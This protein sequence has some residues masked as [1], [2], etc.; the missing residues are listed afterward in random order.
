MERRE[1]LKTV[2]ATAAV[3]VSGRAAWSGGPATAGPAGTTRPARAPLDAAAANRAL[4]EHRIAG[5][6]LRQMRDRFPRLVGPGAR[7]RPTGHGGGFRVRIVTT[8]QGVSGWA[9]SGGAGGEDRLRGRRVSDCFS[10]EHGIASDVPGFLDRVLHDLAGRIL[11]RPVYQLLGGAGPTAVPIYSS[12][13]H[14][15]DLVPAGK[16]GGVPRLLDCCKQDHRAGYRAFKLKIGR[17]FRWMKRNEGLRRDIAITRSVREHFPDCRLLVDAND[18]Y[19]VAEAIAYVKAVADCDLYWI[20]EPFEENRDGLKRLRAAMA[21]V[22]CKAM[23]AD[24]ESRKTRGEPPYP[25]GG[26]AK[27]FVDNL[28]SLAADK[29]VDVFVMDLDIVGFSR[30]RRIMP[31]FVKAGVKTSPHTWMWTPRPYYVAHLA[32]GVGNVCIVEG[33]PGG[34]KDIDYSGFRLKGGNLMV[35]DAPGFGLRLT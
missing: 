23:I 9:S 1:F 16:P 24:G 21:A 7:G 29:L 26:Y 28:F 35:P 32:A 2:G 33:I 27:A 31:A 4:A 34:A 19:T 13:I 11:K 6:E 12:S 20:E 10:T 3:M 22:G 25:Y 30:W 14:F 8:D 18:G 5:I 15:E 17:G